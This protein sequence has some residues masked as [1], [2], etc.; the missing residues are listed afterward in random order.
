MGKSR[1]IANERLVWKGRKFLSGRRE[2]RE[3]KIR[4]DTLL[5]CGTQLKFSSM[6]T[7]RSLTVDEKGMLHPSNTRGA[8]LSCS[9]ALLCAAIMTEH[10]EH[11]GWER[12]ALAARANATG[13][14]LQWLLDEKVAKVPKYRYLSGQGSTLCLLIFNW[15]WVLDKKVAKVSLLMNNSMFR[16]AHKKCHLERCITC[17]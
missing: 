11:V 16:K 13:T 15:P 10:W 3:A 9:T 12:A 2:C 4:R 1:D 14:R 7:P 6:V 8:E 5:T 17:S